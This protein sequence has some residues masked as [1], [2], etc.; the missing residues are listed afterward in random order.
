MIALKGSALLTQWLTGLIA[1][2]CPLVSRLLPATFGR[3]LSASSSSAF[4]CGRE[5]ALLRSS[6]E[7]LHRARDTI[8]ET[9]LSLDRQRRD[10]LIDAGRGGVFNR[11]SIIDVL[12]DPV[13]VPHVRPENGAM[14][15][16]SET[17][18]FHRL[19]LTRQVGSS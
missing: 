6:L 8:G 4:L 2:P 13:L 9:T 14:I 17:Y 7:L 19:D 3:A 5:V 15:L 18:H 10:D 11:R 12:A 1:A 16:K